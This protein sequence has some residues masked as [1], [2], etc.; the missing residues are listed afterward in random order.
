LLTLAGAVLGTALQAQS[1]AAGAPR[2]A[3]AQT[4]LAM[5][6]S[7]IQDYGG[8]L[9]FVDVFRAS[10][11]WISQARGLPHGKGPLLQLDEHGWVKAIEPGAWAETLMCTDLGGKY[12]A[13]QYTVLYDGKGK[14]EFGRDARVVSEA[15]G[16]IIIEVTPRNGFT[17]MLRDTDPADYVRNIR[18]IMP[19]FDDAYAREQVFHPA[20]LARW[21]GMASLRFMDWM[22]TNNSRQ[23]SWDARPKLSDATWGAGI[24]A[25]LELMIDLSNRLKIDP[26]FCMPHLADDDYVR[27]F[28]EMVKARLDPSLKPHIELSNEVWNGQF[29]QTKWAQER[30]VALG[31][32]DKSRP[33]EGG[34]RFYAQRSVEIFRIWEQVFGGRERLVRIIAWQAGSGADW[35]DGRLLAHTRGAADVDALAIAPYFSMNIPGR[36]DRPDAL[37]AEVVATWTLDQVFAHLESESLPKAIESMKRHKAVADRHGIRLMCYEAG[38]HLVGIRSGENN[39]AMT[40]LFHQANRDPRMGQLYRRYIDAWRETG[41]DT[42]AIFSSVG[43]WSKWGSW[44]LAEHFEQRPAESPKYL[45]VLEAAKA[46]GQNVVFDP[47]QNVPATAAAAPARR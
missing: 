35:T 47:W 42:M 25:P 31:L 17:L 18:V 2:P 6:L 20:F 32:G 41:G 37:T 24:G 4:R 44:S 34:A 26:W 7:S 8:E 9:P 5:N 28:A 43:R 39:D 40:K 12:P 36:S 33:W 30:G 23:G 16:R 15:P 10:R 11:N 45:A 19:G 14:I 29:Q 22:R 21:K 46:L 1:P 38:Q 13:G 3:P 27:R